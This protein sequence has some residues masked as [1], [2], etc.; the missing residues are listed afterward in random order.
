MRQ[1][2]VKLVTLGNLKYPVDF[3]LIE[4]WK[5]KLFTAQHIDQIQ[6]LPNMDGEDWSYS[7]YLLSELVKPDTHYDL[8]VGIINA[9]L[10]DNYYVRRVGE[11]TCVLSLD[12]TA[13]ILRDANLTIE[14][15]IIRNLYEFCVAYLEHGYLE[16]DSGTPLIE[17]GIAH[18]ETRGCLFDMCGNKADIVFSTERP[19]LCEPCKVR[20]MKSQV[21]KDLVPSVEREL[22]LIR[23]AL[24]YRLTD[25]VRDKPILAIVVT[26]TGAILLS[27]L[28][29]AIYDALK[30]LI[31][32]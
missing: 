29:N 27:V 10:E 25:F 12:E 31:A 8:T 1:I 17:Y 24:Y 11:Y 22:P 23:K 32:Q 3:R 7:D 18:D 30:L 4:K 6:A 19:R 28:S 16:Y 9:S 13:T 2:K 26:S 5:S 14:N 21:S 20:I 15:F